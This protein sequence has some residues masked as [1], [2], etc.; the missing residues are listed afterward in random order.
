MIPRLMLQYTTA[1]EHIK[2]INII[3]DASNYM[4]DKNDSILKL[5]GFVF[6]HMQV[7]DWGGTYKYMGTGG[8][9]PVKGKCM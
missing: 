9:S 4:Q 6:M 7:Y 5:G 8:C 2:K 3:Y 1:I